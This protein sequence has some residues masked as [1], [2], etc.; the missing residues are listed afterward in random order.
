MTDIPPEVQDELTKLGLV[1]VPAPES[2]EPALAD[3]PEPPEPVVEAVTAPAEEA[4]PPEPT[5]EVSEPP[6]APESE[7]PAAPEVVASDPKALLA[8]VHELLTHLESLL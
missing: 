5:P 3:Q 1:A 7:Q 4:P 8:Q 6:A 2:A